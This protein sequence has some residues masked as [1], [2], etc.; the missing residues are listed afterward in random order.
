M[1]NLEDFESNETNIDTYLVDRII[2][3]SL[4][5]LKVIK[6]NITDFI[7]NK[8]MKN[9]KH[10]QNIYQIKRDSIINYLQENTKN[11]SAN[12]INQYNSLLYD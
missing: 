1:S 6:K 12:K 10:Y 11:L 8:D 3:N 2:Q 5:E 9:I 4:N 7:K